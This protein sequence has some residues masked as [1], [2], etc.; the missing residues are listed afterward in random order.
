ME[1]PGHNLAAV[2]ETRIA[3]KLVERRALRRP[4]D[5]LAPYTTVG[6]RAWTMARRHRAG[7]EGHI[8][9][10][11]SSRHE[12]N[13]WAAWVMAIISA[14]AVGSRNCSR[15]LCAGPLRVG[16]GRSPPRWGL[17]LP[18]QPGGPRPKRFS[19]SADEAP[20]RPAGS[21]P[22]VVAGR[23]NDHYSGCRISTISNRS[24]PR[25]TWISTLSPT[26]LPIMPCASGLV[27]RILPTS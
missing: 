15:W 18:R 12:P 14:W 17:R 9:V 5:R 20:A 25:G 7:F 1:Y 26:F 2:V 23:G 21:V 22:I 11:P 3:E 16:H 6:M 4:W 8:E 27:T 24:T 19:C 13:D 10:H